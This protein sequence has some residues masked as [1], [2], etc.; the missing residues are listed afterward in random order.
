MAARIIK[1]MVWYGNRVDE[2]NDKINSHHNDIAIL[3]LAKKPLYEELAELTRDFWEAVVEPAANATNYQVSIDPSDIHSYRHL[4]KMS[5]EKLSKSLPSFFDG[6]TITYNDSIT[7]DFEKENEKKKLKLAFYPP[8]GYI[9]SHVGE[10][11][12]MAILTPLYF[13]QKSGSGGPGWDHFREENE[14]ESSMVQWKV[15]LGSAPQSLINLIKS[16][17]ANLLPRVEA[18]RK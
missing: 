2:I 4:E 10:P 9:S 6:I 16:Y 13:S 15:D 17:E 12:P 5:F 18:S 7:I 11:R 8:M 14:M 1:N 3:K